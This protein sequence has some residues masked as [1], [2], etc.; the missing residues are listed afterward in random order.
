MVC[1][2]R[3]VITAFPSMLAA[4]DIERCD[5]NIKENSSSHRTDLFGE[6]RLI[7]RRGQPFTIVLHVKPDGSEFRLDDTS[8][9]LVAE[10]GKLLPDC[11]QLHLDVI[12][13]FMTP[14]HASCFGFNLQFDL[15]L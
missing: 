15:C 4:F 8:F 6:Q 13:V 10:T 3:G 14:S 9:S 1:L 7:V 5:L 12:F 11:N 2:L